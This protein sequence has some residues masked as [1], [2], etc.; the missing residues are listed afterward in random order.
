[1]LAALAIGTAAAP[2]AGAAT[3]G[4]CRFDTAALAFAGTP[5][6]QARCLLRPV[7]KWGAIGNVLPALPAKLGGLVG[8]VPTITPDQLAAYVAAKGLVVGNV[9][10]RVSRARDN[11]PAAP[12]ARYFVIHDTSTPWFGNAQFPAD[13]DT[14]ADVNDMAGYLDERDD[15]SPVAHY[16]LNRRGEVAIGHRL[17]I[18]WRAT[19][20]E[21]MVGIP[22]KGLFLHVE[23]IQP[24]R[25]DPNGG[26]RNDAIAPEPG[27][28]AV[29]YQ[30]LA[31]LY[32]IASVRAGKWLIPAFHTVLDH[33]LSDAHDDP[34]NFDLAAFDQALDR[35]TAEIGGQP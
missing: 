8:T 6:Q 4:V 35:V 9:V 3:I 13:I 24:R 31:L 15:D 20:F 33:G 30:G 1:M 7:K 27:L 16:F 21:M 14:S 19:K 2:A 25:R 29:Q 22:A 23:N 32:T 26:A 5:A 34:Q 10:G 28:T 17:S 18:P 12:P 11:S